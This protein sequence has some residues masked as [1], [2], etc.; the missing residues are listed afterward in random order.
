VTGITV[1]ST[2]I[3]NIAYS[4]AVVAATANTLTMNPQDTA[5]A[6]VDLSSSSG[7]SFKWKCG[8]TGTTVTAKYL[9]SA[10]R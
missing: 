10:C 1:D 4:T 8:G 2:G 5:S 7:L 6:A 9:P 3:I